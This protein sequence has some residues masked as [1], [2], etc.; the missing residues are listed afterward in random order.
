[1]AERV[2]LVDR[3]NHAL[4]A[5]GKLDAHRHGQWHGAFSIFLIRPAGGKGEN[6]AELR[7]KTA[8]T[9]VGAGR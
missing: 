3:R 5:A 7:A 6:E 8:A 1:M 2:F 9:A 4:G